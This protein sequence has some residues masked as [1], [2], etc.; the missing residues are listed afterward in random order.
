MNLAPSTDN[1]PIPSPTKEGNAKIIDLQRTLQITFKRA[2]SLLV[3]TLGSLRSEEMNKIDPLGNEIMASILIYGFVNNQGQIDPG[4]RG[5]EQIVESMKSQMV[6]PREI[7]RTISMQLETLESYGLLIQ[8]NGDYKLD[9]KSSELNPSQSIARNVIETLR[10]SLHEFSLAAHHVR[11]LTEQ[12]LELLKKPS[13]PAV[14]PKTQTTQEE[15]MPTPAQ[16]TATP[17]RS[18][19]TLFTESFREALERLRQQTL[20]MKM[21]ATDALTSLEHYRLHLE[22]SKLASVEKRSGIQALYNPMAQALHTLNPEIKMETF[23]S[24]LYAVF[25][26][27]A[28]PLRAGTPLMDITQKSF[29]SGSE[30]HS[31]KELIDIMGASAAREMKKSDAIQESVHKLMLGSINTLSIAKIGSRAGLVPNDEISLLE[32]ITHFLINS[33]GINDFTLQRYNAFVAFSR[34]HLCPVLESLRTVNG[35]RLI[36]GLNE[37]LDRIEHIEKATPIQTLI[38]STYWNTIADTLE[39]NRREFNRVI[40]VL[41]NELKLPPLEHES[42]LLLLEHHSA[43]RARRMEVKVANDDPGLFTYDSTSPLGGSR[44]FTPR[45]KNV[46]N[47]FK[48]V[49]DKIITLCHDLSAREDGPHPRFAQDVETILE[50]YGW[51]SEIKSPRQI[52]STRLIKELQ[53]GPEPRERLRHVSDYLLANQVKVMRKF[54]ETLESIET[55]SSPEL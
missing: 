40:E 20:D 14:Q 23:Q 26:Q 15:S 41:E 34:D 17:I 5:L 33:P 29:L 25:P 32:N 46:L 49:V 42:R 19:E 36:D 45:L 53:N 43:I 28:P 38:T 3:L 4:R 11:E 39:A 31:F 37:I 30:A 51:S 55:E 12:K 16:Q 18:P 13:S 1:R 48:V 6:V 8:K 22:F 24:F 52:F 9:L 27:T 47:D 35:S 21:T 50:K 54:A 7:W 10:N 2:E 44:I